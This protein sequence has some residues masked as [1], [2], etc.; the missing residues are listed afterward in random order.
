MISQ[1]QIKQA[2]LQRQVDGIAAAIESLQEGYA[3]PE[4]PLPSMFQ[5]NGGGDEH[6]TDENP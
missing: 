2:E 4:M 5:T 3:L 1:L 6:H